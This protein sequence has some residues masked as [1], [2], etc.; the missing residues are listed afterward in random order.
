M[1]IGIA[2][3]AILVYQQGQKKITIYNNQELSALKIPE[4]GVS[5]MY[6]SKIWSVEYNKHTNQPTMLYSREKLLESASETSEN[7][8]Y[9]MYWKELPDQPIGGYDEK[10]WNELSQCGNPSHVVGSFSQAVNGARIQGC[11][12]TIYGRPN[13]ALFFV[14]PFSKHTIILYGSSRD[15]QSISSKDTNES[16]DVDAI[17][18]EFEKIVLSFSFDNPTKTEVSQSVIVQNQKDAVD[19]EG[20]VETIQIMSMV[21]RE[22]ELHRAD[23]GLFP[24]SLKLNDLYNMSDYLRE[25][26]KKQ[27]IHYYK[28]SDKDDYHLAVSLKTDSSKNDPKIVGL[29]DDSDLNHFCLGDPISGN[30]SGKCLS[31]DVGNYC[32]DVNRSKSI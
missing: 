16:V 18:K 26:L 19:T 21:R 29:S 2:G 14:H 5:L 8:R 27:A 12:K 17:H 10:W 32:Y 20:D 22:I 7:A 3:S 15:Q 24:S 25:Q 28:C 1:V 13:T 31:G 11:K 9:F 6:D 30:D 23:N 4:V